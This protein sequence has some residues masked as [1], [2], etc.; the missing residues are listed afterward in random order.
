[1]TTSDLDPA[2]LAEL[3]PTGRLRAGINTGN[4]LLVSG[5]TADGHPVGVSPDVAA[6]IARRLDVELEFVCYPDP[7]LLADAADRGEW[8]IGNI[9]AEPQRAR[10]IAFTSAYCQIEATYLVP[11]GSPITTIDEV[12]QPGRRVATKGRAAYGLWLE[13]NLKHAELVRTESIDDSFDAFVEQE[14]DALAGLRPRLLKDFER[15]PGARIL[16]GQFSAVQQSVG[17]PRGNLKAAEWLAEVIEELKASGF[18]AG[19]I[20]RH[21]VQGLSV[22]PRADGPEGT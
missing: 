10:T 20:E 4:F 21:A 12:D 6:E 17:T 3:A 7:G 22:A 2:L 15:L 11:A 9:G 16:E 1:M 5:H 19:L 18:I 8:D 13:N 14:L